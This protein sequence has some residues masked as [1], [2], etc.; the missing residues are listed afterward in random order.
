MNKK[1]N[2]SFAFV[3][4]RE[5]NPKFNL[6]WL[7]HWITD[8]ISDETINKSCFSEWIL[9]FEDRYTD[10]EIETMMEAWRCREDDMTVVNKLENI[11]CSK[12]YENAVGII[13]SEGNQHIS[14]TTICVDCCKEVVKDYEDSTKVSMKDCQTCKGKGWVQGSVCAVDCTNCD[15]V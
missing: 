11:F 6:I 9:G 7:R 5:P 3:H 1:I 8:L 14:S 13:L 10:V 2:N 4:V 15:G 12:C